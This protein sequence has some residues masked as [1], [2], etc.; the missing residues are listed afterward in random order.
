MITHLAKP[1]SEELANIVVPIIILSIDHPLDHRAD[2]ICRCYNRCSS[3]LPVP[4]GYLSYSLFTRDRTPLPFH[5]TG[6]KAGNDL[7]L[8]KEDKD[9]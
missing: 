8:E 2:F 6:C 7:T 3:K 9:E 4:G 1:V 5:R